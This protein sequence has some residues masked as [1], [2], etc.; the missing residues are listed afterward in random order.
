MEILV[1]TESTIFD[2]HSFNSIQQASINQRTTFPDISC[3]VV[4]P[5][6]SL[7]TKNKKIKSN[8][9]FISVVLCKITH[10]SLYRK[11]LLSPW[12]A[13]TPF[14]V[15]KF[16]FFWFLFMVKVLKFCSNSHILLLIFTCSWKGVWKNYTFFWGFWFVI[17]GL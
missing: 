1:L 4:N 5:P 9:R 7:R 6:I 11:L 3:F 8:F 12:V 2:S 16:Y 10:F 14:Q 13:A 15:I 17:L